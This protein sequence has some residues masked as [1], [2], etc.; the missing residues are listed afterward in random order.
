M[1]KV[2][3]YILYISIYEGTYMCKNKFMFWFNKHERRL[4]S[5]SQ[6]QRRIFHIIK[7]NNHNIDYVRRM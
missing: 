1:I 7:I 4:F 6:N 2:F 3:R 5:K